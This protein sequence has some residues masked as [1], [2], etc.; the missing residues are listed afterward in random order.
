[1]VALCASVGVLAA[2][3]PV[4]N[5]S[6]AGRQVFPSANWW[7][8]DITGAPV[9]ARSAQLI[10]FISG[11]TA[12]NTTAVRRLHP[13]FGPPP[14]GIPYV[15]VAGDQARV[16]LG[17]VAYADESDTGAPGLP[18]YPIPAEARTM[19][20]YIEGGVAGGGSSGDRHMLVIDRDRWLLYETYA[21]RWNAA[22]SQWQADSGAVFDLSRSDQRPTG[23]TSADAAGLAVFPG[24]VRYDEVFSTAEITHAFRVTTHGSNGYVWP[25]SHSAG[26]NA[27]A[28]PMG[29]R[30][31]LKPSR[32]I[33][34]FTPEVQRIFR[35][36]KRYGLIVA[37]NG[38]DMYISGS[39]DSRWNNDVLNPAFSALTADDFEVVQLGWRGG[40]NPPPAAPTN[41]II[42]R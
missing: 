18:G 26:S 35:A 20:N 17:L 22:Q 4:L 37:D 24:L 31:R 10:D 38:S 36:M 42:V 15:V 34:T 6:L 27:S 21:T 30:L 1:V 19:A 39:M 13:D 25:A 2:V 8:T 9:D 14:Y 5:E 32:N 33:S 3:P 40:G 29:T 16:T 28:P 11:R 41:L 7:N 23:W 12:T